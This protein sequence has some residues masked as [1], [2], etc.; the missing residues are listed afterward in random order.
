MAQDIEI[1]LSGPYKIVQVRVVVNGK[2][3]RHIILPG[4][5]YS[6]ELPEVQEVCAREH[7]QDV[8]DAYNIV[9]KESEL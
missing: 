1:T 7:T 9:L 8:I 3:H 5:D 2:Y 4:Q 6:Q